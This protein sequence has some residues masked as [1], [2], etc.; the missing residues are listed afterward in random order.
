MGNDL[1]SPAALA[2]LP[3]AP[4]TD[5]AVDSAVAQIRNEAGWHIAPQKTETLTLDGPGTSTLVLPS[6]L[7]DSVTE[8]R[9]VTDPAAPTV[10]TGWRLGKTILYLDG[11]WPCGDA[12]LEVDLVHGY[13]EC[14]AD[15]LP[16]VA[17]VARAEAVNASVAREKAGAF[18]VEYA[19]SAEAAAS[20][21]RAWSKLDPYR[22]R[23]EF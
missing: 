23:F 10:I 16:L 9:D 11:C 17:A 12:V 7:V 3:G 14:P 18:E 20:A 13:A 19:D 5:V 6:R 1:T 2:N 4:F 8:V 15:L 22:A 21:D